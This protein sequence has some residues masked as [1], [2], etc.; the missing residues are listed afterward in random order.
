MSRS[1]VFYCARCAQAEPLGAWPW[2][3][4]G[5]D[6]GE[7]LAGNIVREARAYAGTGAHHDPD[8]YLKVLMGPGDQ[9]PKYFLQ[10]SSCGLYARGVMRLA[11]VDHPILKAPYRVEHAVSDILE[12]AASKDAWV[13][14]HGPTGPHPREGD[15]FLIRTPGKNDDH[16][17]IITA[18]KGEWHFETAAGGQGAGGT[19]SGLFERQW[20]VK[21]GVLH[22]G[23]RAVVGWAD[24]RKLANPTKA[25]PQPVPVPPVPVPPR[26]PAPAPVQGGTFAVAVLGLFGLGVLTLSARRRRAA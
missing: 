26:P 18:V 16:V 1:E 23:D 15:L 9:D 25:R 12:I 14:A 11:G 2:F 21:H 13:E 4:V 6:V 10:A 7:L 5:A 3:Y 19:E 22:Q 8:L 24:G 20:V 17:E